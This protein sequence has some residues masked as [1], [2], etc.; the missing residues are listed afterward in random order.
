MFKR[1]AVA[2]GA[3]LVFGPAFADDQLV[4]FTPDLTATFSTADA[5]TVLDGGDDIIAFDHLISG[6]TYNFLLTFSSQHIDLTEVSL[7]GILAGIDGNATPNRV[8]NF[9]LLYDAATAPLQLKVV[10]TALNAQ[11]NYS[12]ELSVTAVPEPETYSLMLAGLAVMGFIAR[13]RPRA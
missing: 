11:A 12:G 1:L 6:T 7:N 2:V 3:A 4:H 5:V 10:G 8:V 9:A 13:R